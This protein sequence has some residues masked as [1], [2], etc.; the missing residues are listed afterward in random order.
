MISARREKGVWRAKTPKGEVAASL[1]LLCTG[2][3]TGEVG[4]R[5]GLEIPIRPVRRMVFATAPAPFPHAFPLTIDLATG[6]YLRSE[7][8]RVLMGRSNPD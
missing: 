7:G 5:L 6:F 1:L 2:A 4:K 3:W 8:A